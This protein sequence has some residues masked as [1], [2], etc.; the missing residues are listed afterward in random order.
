L[1]QLAAGPE[2]DAG[3]LADVDP[4]ATHLPV[5]GVEEIARSA[6]VR[7]DFAGA[8]TGEPATV[9]A[10]YDAAIARAAS[11]E[12]R[13]H[14]A[15]FTAAVGDL[16]QTLG[17]L[18]DQVTLVAPVNGTYSLA[19][20]DA[21]LVLTVQ[22]DLPFAVDVRL[23]LEARGKVGL[24]TEDI[25]VQTLEPLSRTTLQVPA[26]VQQSGG[27]AVTARL[28]TPDGG[29]LGDPVQMQVKST[30]YGTLTLAIT[31]G[32]AALLALL[33]LRRG[34]RFLLR[35]RRGAT[36]EEPPVDGIAG[37]PPTRSPV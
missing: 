10:G 14:E 2:V 8:V 19:S 5:E 17:R 32:A 4:A 26:H 25:G 6:A 1:D 34:V 29:P 24:T 13:G 18:R 27:F 33:F 11:A 35:R 9:L 12:W 30:A 31:I 23:V 21:P 3:D 28:T 7:D 22:N 20:G 36:A 37:V 15:A 16:E